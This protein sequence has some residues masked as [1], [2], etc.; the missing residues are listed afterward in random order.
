MFCR[1]RGVRSEKRYEYGMSDLVR[2]TGLSYKALAK[3]IER[4]EFIMG[5][6]LSLAKWLA[7]RTL[8]DGAKGQT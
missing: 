5:D 1:K 8:I 6:L 7:G 2:I 4:G 3:R